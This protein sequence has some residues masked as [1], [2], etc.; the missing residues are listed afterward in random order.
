MSTLKF[1]RRSPKN[2]P[3]LKLANYLTGVVPAHP[4]A[5]D[6]LATL[7]DW[8]ML[9]NDQWGDC[10]AVT[11]A[12][13]RRLLSA[14]L[15]GKEEYPDLDQ[16]L[17]FYKTQNPDFPQQDDGMDIQ[18]ALEEL[19]KNGGPDGVKALGFAKVDHTNVDEVKAAIAI[20]GC[21]WTG[22]NVLNANMNEFNANEPW[23]YK[24]ASGVDGGHSVITGGYGPA[25]AGALG[26]DERFIT[27]AQE[28][29]FTDAFWSHQVDEAWVVIWPEHVGTRAFLEGVDL[30]ALAADYT[31]LTGRPFP[32][33][34]PPAPTPNPPPAPLD[35]DQQLALAQEAWEA[36]LNPTHPQQRHAVLRDA[37]RAWRAAKGL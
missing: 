8:Q 22:V 35:V 25:G 6:Y 10:V 29:S 2:A 19:V 13:E 15:G 20:F 27:W 30:A 37:N 4:D 9:G 16:V 23:D 7:S 24:P 26:G 32:V 31:A 18:T 3:A 14:C 21:V 36:T 12:G 1:G 28:T 5:A 33:T 11:W 17:E 34:P